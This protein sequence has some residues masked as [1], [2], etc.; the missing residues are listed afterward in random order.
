MIQTMHSEAFNHHPAQM[1]MCCGQ[2][3]F[4]LPS[5]GAG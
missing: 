3:K 2:Q 4:G 1:L 5:V